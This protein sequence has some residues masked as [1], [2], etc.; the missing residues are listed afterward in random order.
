MS[1]IRNAELFA[2]K[3]PRLEAEVQNCLKESERFAQVIRKQLEK[4]VG[5][6]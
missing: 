2:E 5:D 4:V 3:Y 1:N 6:E